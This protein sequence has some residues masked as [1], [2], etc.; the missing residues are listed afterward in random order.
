MNILILVSLICY[1]TSLQSTNSICTDLILTNQKDFLKNP[2]VLEVGI[3]HQP[4]FITTVLR[5]RLVRGNTKMKMYQGF[6]T[7]N[8]NT[9]NKD[10]KECLKNHT[11]Y[12]YL[13][14]KNN[15]NIF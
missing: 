13:F 14:V 15:N 8:I 2:N 9:L 11:V 12:N 7:F 6:K 3:C 5:N 4:S 10:I 1:T